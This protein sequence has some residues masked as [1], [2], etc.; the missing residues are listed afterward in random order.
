MGICNNSEHNLNGKSTEIQKEKLIKKIEWIKKKLKELNIYHPY[1]IIDDTSLKKLQK[2]NL[3]SISDQ[4]ETMHK[5][6]EDI[7]NRQDKQKSHN[8]KRN[9][10]KEVEEYKEGKAEKMQTN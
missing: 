2:A 5:N 10:T 6:R 9:K 7:L 3:I 4:L 1:D 8:T